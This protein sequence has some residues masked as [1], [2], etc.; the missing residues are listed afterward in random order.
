MESEFRQ[1]L[2]HQTQHSSKGV[3]V[4]NRIVAVAVAL[5]LVAGTIA[6]GADGIENDVRALQSVFSGV[7]RMIDGI[8]ARL[9]SLG[10]RVVTNGRNIEDVHEY[11]TSIEDDLMGASRVYADRF[12][13]ITKRFEELGNVDALRDGVADLWLEIEALKEAVAELQATEAGEPGG[14]PRVPALD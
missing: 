12:T 6:I 10:A 13:D 2:V 4:K 14:A 3:V 7:V 11:A 9:D 5:S 1:G 8:N